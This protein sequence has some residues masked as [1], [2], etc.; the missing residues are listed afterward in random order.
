MELKILAKQ[1]EYWRCCGLTRMDREK[2]IL[3]ITEQENK[4]GTDTLED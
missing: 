2:N 4:Y 3:Q 1:M